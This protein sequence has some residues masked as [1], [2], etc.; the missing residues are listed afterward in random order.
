MGSPNRDI[1]FLYGENARIK[2]KDLASMLRKSPQLLKYTVR[3]LEQE[4]NVILPHA[5][6]DYSYFGLLLFRVYYK[7]AYISERDKAAILAEFN[8]NNYIT[9]VCELEGE[10]DL[11]LEIIAP[12]PSRFNKELKKSQ[13]HPH[14]Q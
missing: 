8:T 9:S 7:G 14:P 1:L 4:K 3:S 2:L 6:F 5:V 11:A 10:F 13:P 12:N